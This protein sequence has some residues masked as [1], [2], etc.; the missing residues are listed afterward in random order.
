MPRVI[1]EVEPN[2]TIATASATG[3]AP[4]MIE[5]YRRM[6]RF[7]PGLTTIFIV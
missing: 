3:I 5:S 6:P 7:S 1:N 4:A 2:D